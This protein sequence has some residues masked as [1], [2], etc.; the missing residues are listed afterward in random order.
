[1]EK[2][3]E[4][5]KGLKERGEE[6][7]TPSFVITY[8][9]FKDVFVVD[10]PDD[11]KYLWFTAPKHKGTLCY[12]MSGFYPVEVASSNYQMAMDEIKMYSL[13]ATKEMIPTFNKNGEEHMWLETDEEGMMAVPLRDIRIIK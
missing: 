4:R 6:I 12:D 3:L 7:I 13:G 1:M 5:L 9:P 2:I 10:V 8:N 11:K